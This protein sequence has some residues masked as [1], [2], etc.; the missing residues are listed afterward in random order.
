MPVYYPVGSSLVTLDIPYNWEENIKSYMVGMF[1]EMEQEDAKA[2]RLK[3]E[4]MDW[5]KD[6]ARQNRQMMGPVQVGVA[7]GR[8]VAGGGMGGGWFVS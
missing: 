4:F 7:G 2:Q 8:D 1:R 6:L 5:T 3:K